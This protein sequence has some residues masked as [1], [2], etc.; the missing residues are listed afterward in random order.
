MNSP[1][2][3]DAAANKVRKELMEL[4]AANRKKEREKR[5][6]LAFAVQKQR[7]L[8]DL[9]LWKAITTIKAQVNETIK[10]TKQTRSYDLRSI[11]DVPDYYEYQNPT[12]ARQKTNDKN[13]PWVV[14]CLSGGLTEKQLM[15]AAEVSR[16]A[17][18]K[19]IRWKRP[20]HNAANAPAQPV[21]APPRNNVGSGG[22][23]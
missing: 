2:I 22:V 20:D 18:W 5:K 11:A 1:A 15:D 21:A 10:S 12:N 17:M 3:R 14:E 6:Q 8:E 9:D 4:R 16:L 19:K 23:G 7:M 13:A